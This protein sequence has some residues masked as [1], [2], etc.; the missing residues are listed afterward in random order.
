[1]ATNCQD[2]SPHGK[3]NKIIIREWQRLLPV[4]VAIVPATAPSAT[5]PCPCCS[6]GGQT[7]AWDAVQAG[8]H[9]ESQPIPALS[10][11]SDWLS[12]HLLLADE[13]CDQLRIT[14]EEVWEGIHPQNAQLHRQENCLWNRSRAQLAPP[15]G[16]TLT[17]AHHIQWC[18]SLLRNTPIEGGGTIAATSAMFHFSARSRTSTGMP[19]TRAHCKGSTT[20]ESMVIARSC[21]CRSSFAVVHVAGRTS[22]SAGPTSPKEDGNCK[23]WRMAVSCHVR[24]ASR[25]ASWCLLSTV[26]LFWM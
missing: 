20:R 1:M 26:E 7:T 18:E 11:G 3:G 6:D 8:S 10:I 19:R 14:R 16:G 25:R 4:S 5:S 23:A 22:R 2:H 15:E 24:H 12:F 17:M 13:F 9:C 21:L